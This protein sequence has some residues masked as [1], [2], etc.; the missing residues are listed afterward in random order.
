MGS[1]WSKNCPSPYLLQSQTLCKYGI[2]RVIYSL[3]LI[4]ALN[5]IYPL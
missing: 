2:T 3:S 1:I 5:V 4:K